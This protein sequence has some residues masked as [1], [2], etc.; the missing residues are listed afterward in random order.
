[1]QAVAAPD[2]VIED[3]ER[4][5]APEDFADVL[6]LVPAACASWRKRAGGPVAEFLLE[7]AFYTE[8]SLL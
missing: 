3:L 1:M 2:A 8:H 5:M 6:K 4:A 7:A